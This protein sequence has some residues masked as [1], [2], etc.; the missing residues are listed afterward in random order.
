MAGRLAN[1]LRPT[2]SFSN[3]RREASATAHATRPAHAATAARIIAN[4]SEQFPDADR[5]ER[6][7]QGSDSRVWQDWPFSLAARALL[8]DM[9]TRGKGTDLWTL[10]PGFETLRFWFLGWVD[11]SWSRLQISRGRAPYAQGACMRKIENSQC[12]MYRNRHYPTY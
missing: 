1:D 7:A 9:W 6:G 10:R 11:M 4:T 12:C 3:A 8:F 2:S 5:V